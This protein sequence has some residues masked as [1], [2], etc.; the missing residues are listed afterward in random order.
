LIR[1]SEE[2]NEKKVSPKGAKTPR[3]TTKETKTIREA[4]H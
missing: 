2:E 4:E 3:K 1:L